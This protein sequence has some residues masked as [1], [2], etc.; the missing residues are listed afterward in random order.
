MIHTNSHLFHEFYWTKYP[1]K[2]LLSL[3]SALI[4]LVIPPMIPP[5]NP[6]MIRSTA[7]LP[8]NHNCRS[9]VLASVPM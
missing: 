3:V 4:P 1:P 5:L 2:G 6:P 9:F 8:C 7:R